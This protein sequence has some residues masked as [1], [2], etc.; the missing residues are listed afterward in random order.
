MA[1]C[2][3]SGV[4]TVGGAERFARTALPRRS[5]R[6]RR[7]RRRHSAATA[8]QVA[9]PRTAIHVAK[10][11]SDTRAVTRATQGRLRHVEAQHPEILHY[12]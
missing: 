5:A 2:A 9:A 11:A 8:G 6:R 7:A 3:V 10:I 4:V 1:P 12:N